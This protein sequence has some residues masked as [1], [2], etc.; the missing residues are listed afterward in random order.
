MTHRRHRHVCLARGCGA[1]LERW[2]R[3]CLRCWRRLPWDKRRAIAEAKATP[4]IASQLAIEAAQW[5]S[6]HSPAQEAARRLG[7]A[8]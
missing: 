5:L 7:E 2:Q 8:P 1:P 4:H 6:A 3:F